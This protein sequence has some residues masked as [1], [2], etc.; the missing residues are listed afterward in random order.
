MRFVDDQ[1]NE[2]LHL[3]AENLEMVRGVRALFKEE[4]EQPNFNAGLQ[5]GAM[6]VREA[7]RGKGSE[8]QGNRG[9]VKGITW[10]RP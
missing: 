1:Y 2:T 4:G 3:I 10:P 5:V 6:I 8:A 7:Q 9:V